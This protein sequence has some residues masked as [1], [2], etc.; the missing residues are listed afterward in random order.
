MNQSDQTDVSTF[1]AKPAGRPRSLWRIPAI[2]AGA[3]A[4]LTVLSIMLDAGLHILGGVATHLLLSQP[5]GALHL[6][7]AGAATAATGIA[8]LATAV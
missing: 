8:F 5:L 4:G 6:K 2:L 7:I 3:T 1:A